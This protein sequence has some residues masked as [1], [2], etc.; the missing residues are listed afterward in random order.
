MWRALGTAVR[1]LAVLIVGCWLSVTSAQETR[2]TEAAESIRIEEDLEGEV[3]VPLVEFVL[4]PPRIR[5]DLDPELKMILSSILETPTE[6]SEES[7]AELGS[8]FDAKPESERVAQVVID[9]GRV[10]I[11]PDFEEGQS[12]CL[13]SL[14]DDLLMTG[15]VV[16]DAP[17]RWGDVRIHRL[18]CLSHTTRRSSA[19]YMRDNVFFYILR[20]QPDSDALVGPMLARGWPQLCQDEASHIH[21]LLPLP[22]A[23]SD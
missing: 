13:D 10:L 4:A 14:F 6:D 19:A 12:T 18:T 22:L 5:H 21:G 1:G 3:W 16:I 8:G 11:R 23:G 17:I 7:D 20:S 9:Q 15:C 2:D